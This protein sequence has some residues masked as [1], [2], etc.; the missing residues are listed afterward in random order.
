MLKQQETA[1]FEARQQ[2]EEVRVRSIEIA[3]KDS[4]KQAWC[5]NCG[6]EAQFY[7]CSNVSY[8]NEDCQSLDWRKHMTKCER[9]M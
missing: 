1:I 5:A 9:T 2:C 8:C 3:L 4:N 6:K 7:C